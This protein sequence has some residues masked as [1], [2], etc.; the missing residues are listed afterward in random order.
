M[1]F[2]SE[3]FL[4]PVFLNNREC[5]GFKLTNK[6]LGLDL[7]ESDYLIVPISEEVFTKLFHF[8]HGFLSV[9][10]V[11]ENEPKRL[12]KWKIEGVLVSYLKVFGV[13]IELGYS[14]VFDL[15]QIERIPVNKEKICFLPRTD[16]VEIYERDG[17]DLIHL[18]NLD[19]SGDILKYEHLITPVSNNLF[20]DQN[21]LIHVKE[22]AFH[23]YGD[24]LEEIQNE[25]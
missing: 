9:R 20:K 6:D 2:I 17:E 10:L 12:E 25:I 14:L 13:T 22:K 11:S 5:V 1:T 18:S 21:W 24:K 23:I 16:K 15:N 19:N 7:L 8:I 3:K 4:V